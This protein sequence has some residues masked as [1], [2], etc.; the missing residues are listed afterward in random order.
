MLEFHQQVIGL[1]RLQPKKYQQTQSNALNGKGYTVHHQRGDMTE[2]WFKVTDVIQQVDQLKQWWQGLW[3]QKMDKKRRYNV[4]RTKKRSSG[5]TQTRWLVIWN[6]H[7][8]N[9]KTLHPSVYE[10][11]RERR[12]FVHQFYRICI[13]S[14]NTDLSNILFWEINHIIFMSIESTFLILGL[15]G[16]THTHT[17]VYYSQKLGFVAQNCN[18]YVTL[19]MVHI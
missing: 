2:L 7:I 4:P 1:E 3:Q 6:N 19:H 15:Q 8:T 9:T 14:Y 12:D 10:P 11:S 17:E 18:K 13:L 5:R 16:C